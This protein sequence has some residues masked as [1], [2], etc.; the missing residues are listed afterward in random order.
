M[1]VEGAKGSVMAGGMP[2]SPD[3]TPGIVNVGL[4][5]STGLESLISEVTSLPFSSGVRVLMSLF[6][7]RPIES[8]MSSVSL[9]GVVSLEL[10]YPTVGENEELVSTSMLSPTDASL[11]PDS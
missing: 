1:T 11:M 5:P 3:D 9:L 8:S 2:C 4:L 7:S 10:A 6:P